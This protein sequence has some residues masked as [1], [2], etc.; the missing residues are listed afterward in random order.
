[1]LYRKFEQEFTDRPIEQ[2]IFEAKSEDGTGP[3]LYFQNMEYRIE[4]YIHGR[5]I[6][7]W[8][9]RNPLIYM[10]LAEMFCDYNFSAVVQEKIK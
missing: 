9:M 2:A 5:P 4:S 1:M 6:S 7:I 10:K 8:E 3:K